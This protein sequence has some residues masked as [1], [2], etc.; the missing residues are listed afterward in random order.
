MPSVRTT[1]ARCTGTPS[2]S[3]EQP[4]EAGRIE[5]IVQ[6]GAPSRLLHAVDGLS[7]AVAIAGGFLPELHVSADAHDEG[8]VIAGTQNAIEEIE[9]GSFLFQQDALDRI[10]DVE[11]DAQPQREI[12]VAREVL[13]SG[14]RKLVVEDADVVG[15]K[16]L[17]Q[18]PLRVGHGE[19]Q[20]DFG[21]GVADGVSRGGGEGRVAYRRS[22][23][24]G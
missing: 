2:S 24:R 7:Q 11:N 15:R 18:T 3:V 8:K 17:H 5:S 1:I 22:D 4:V 12:V 13:Q 9:R 16:V 21:H 10:A 14:N 23:Y 19:L 6:D 20:A